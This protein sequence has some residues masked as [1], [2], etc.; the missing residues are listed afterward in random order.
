MLINLLSLFCR[1]IIA[2]LDFQFRLMHIY[3]TLFYIFRSK[4]RF[5]KSAF[6]GGIYK[7]VF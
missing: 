5:L 3:M 4:P 1:K 6:S 2:K 7:L